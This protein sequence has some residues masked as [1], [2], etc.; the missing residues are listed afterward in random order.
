MEEQGLTVSQL[1]EYTVPNL[2]DYGRG[3]MGKKTAKLKRN[4]MV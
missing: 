1:Q 4:Y 2:E 3:N